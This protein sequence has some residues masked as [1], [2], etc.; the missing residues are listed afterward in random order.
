[1]VLNKSIVFFDIETTGLS[2]SE[3]RIIEL[4]M[5]KVHPDR[6]TETWYSLINPEGRK[7]SKEAIDKHGIE[8]ESLED[9]DTFSY[10]A[11]EILE[12]I[13]GCD[14]GGYNVMGF[15][16]PLLAEEFLRAGI[17][18]N[19]RDYNVV[20]S[21]AIYRH[22]EPR[23]LEAAYKKYTGK[24]LENAHSAIADAEATVE[25][26][27]AQLDFYNIDGTVEELQNETLQKDEMVD[28]AGKFKKRNNEI[29]INFGKHI[30]KNVREVY[31]EDPG[32]L[33]WLSG[34]SGFTKETKL[35]SSRILSK[36]KSKNI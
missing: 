17:P 16:L 23:N 32:Y 2:I 15:D 36:L 10:L 21:L 22:Y 1:M 27:F 33:E 18:F 4:C 8:N 29:V 25:V 28:I 7:S 19:H 14:L 35:I 31:K 34:A 26:F 3:D 13:E 20:D 30:G 12:F 6:D 9:K 11:P 24:V 5:V